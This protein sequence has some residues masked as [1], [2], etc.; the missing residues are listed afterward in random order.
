MFIFFTIILIAIGLSM[1]TFSLSL[2][3]GMILNNKKD[4]IK[5]SLTVGLFHFFMP[6]IGNSIGLYLE[7]IFNLNEDFIIG[8]I[9]LIISI[10][11][12]ISLYKKEEIK[13]LNNNK[14]IL[15]FSLAVSLDSFSTGIGLSAIKAPILLIVS[16]FFITSLLFT[17]IGLFLG[18]EINNYIGNK[19]QII[20][21]IILIILSLKYIAES[22]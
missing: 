16:I 11:L 7:D 6:I 22:L 14:E 5:I 2:S 21:I 17:Y 4:I 9:F 18:K 15:I 19:S 10:E 20:G 8:I 3:Y 13:V 1:D 12:I